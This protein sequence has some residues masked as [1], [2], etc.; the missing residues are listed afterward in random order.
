MGSR[1]FDNVSTYSENVYGFEKCYSRASVTL[2][3]HVRH[4][5]SLTPKMGLKWASRRLRVTQM[6]DFDSLSETDKATSSFKV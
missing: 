3:Q 1:F 2:V 4:F 5:C 6:G